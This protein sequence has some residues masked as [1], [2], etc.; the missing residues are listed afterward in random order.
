MKKKSSLAVAYRKG[1]YV[2]QSVDATYT[3][4]FGTNNTLTSPSVGSPDNIK[5][6]GFSVTFDGSEH[7]TK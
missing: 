7:G 5:N 2:H 6:E 4:G 1:K 3:T